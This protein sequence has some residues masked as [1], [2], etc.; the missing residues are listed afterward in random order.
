[1]VSCLQPRDKLGN[2]RSKN[3]EMPT[4]VWQADN[5]ETEGGK[6]GRRKGLEV[7]DRRQRKRRGSNRGQ[8]EGGGYGA[9]EVP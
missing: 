1:M 8:E 5:G 3:I 4:I 2:G 7:N 6:S 9:Q